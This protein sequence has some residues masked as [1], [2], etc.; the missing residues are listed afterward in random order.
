MLSIFQPGVL[1]A[2]TKTDNLLLVLVEPKC[3]STSYSINSREY[4][5]EQLYD[6]LGDLLIAK[7][8]E[9]KVVVLFSQKSALST[10]INLRG[11]IQKVG[12]G[13]I[14]YFYY[15]ED[16]KMMA[17]VNLDS[18]AIPYSTDPENFK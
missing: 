8:R 13:D 7:G 17:E 18:Y 11:T 4:D 2:G 3:N 14:R 12:F 10:I 1:I 9:V 6:Y 15:G 16:K 5:L